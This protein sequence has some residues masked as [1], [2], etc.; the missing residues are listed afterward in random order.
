MSL[1]DPSYKKIVKKNDI[2]I[3]R[4][5]ST[6]DNKSPIVVGGDERFRALLSHHIF[7][8]FLRGKRSEDITAF[9][10]VHNRYIIIFIANTPMNFFNVKVSAR[11]YMIFTLRT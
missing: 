4:S 3:C 2:I 9:F 6:L 11:I 5:L 8:H 7:K 1:N 10:T